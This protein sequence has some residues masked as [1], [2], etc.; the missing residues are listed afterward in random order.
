MGNIALDEAN[1]RIYM[2]DNNG[3][4]TIRVYSYRD[5]HHLNESLELVTTVDI[6]AI[7]VQFSNMDALTS[8]GDGINYYTFSNSNIVHATLGTAGD[9]STV[10]VSSFATAWTPVPATGTLTFGSRS[11]LQYHNGYLYTGSQRINTVGDIYYFTRGTSDFYMNV[12]NI[13]TVAS[14]DW[15]P[16][17]GYLYPEPTA[18]TRVSEMARHPITGQWWAHCQSSGADTFKTFPF[19]VA[20]T[21]SI[22]VSTVAGLTSAAVIRGM[23]FNETG[24]LLLILQEDS[25]GILERAFYVMGMAETLPDLYWPEVSILLDM[26]DTTTPTDKSGYG[27]TVALVGTASLS[28]SEFKFNTQSL[29]IP[30]ANTQ[31]L[32][33][34]PGSG[35]ELE[36]G[37][38]D[39]TIEFWFKRASTYAANAYILDFRPASTN[40]AYITLYFTIAESVR[41][42]TNSADRISG[43][44]TISASVFTHIALCRAS[45]TTRLFINGAQ[46][47]ADYIDATSYLKGSSIRV[48]H[49]NF[50]SLPSAYGWMDSLRITS[51][52]ARYTSDFTPGIHPMPQEGQE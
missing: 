5:L 4:T 38:G 27:H 9:W 20:A 45:G 14:P 40:G 29:S 46:D 8:L 49:S 18:G 11:A 42:Y 6:E 15:R 47:G 26:E 37:T 3:N 35:M 44:V 10:S 13:G 52:I 41:F 50:G 23:Q 7:N 19:G 16:S 33:I 31:G 48:G 34:D 28:T 22:E 21:E 32:S 51:G 1:N 39:F 25:S 36:F 30:N 24:S 12:E 17:Q 43:A 2:V